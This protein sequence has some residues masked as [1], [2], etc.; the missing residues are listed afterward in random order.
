MKV[1]DW[2]VNDAATPL[3]FTLEV[4]VR[5]LPIIVMTLLTR[6]EVGA[7]ST[8]GASPVDSLKTEP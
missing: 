6:P 4:P 1:S 8:S 7:V 3:N 5:P 2:T